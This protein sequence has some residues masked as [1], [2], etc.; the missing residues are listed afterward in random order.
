MTH[1]LIDIPEEIYIRLT[2]LKRS[3][4]TIP[5]LL[6]RLIK[7]STMPYFYQALWLVW[8]VTLVSEL[9]IQ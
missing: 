2:E 1:K 5:D 8:M 3:N 6:N 4:E 7:K 9:L